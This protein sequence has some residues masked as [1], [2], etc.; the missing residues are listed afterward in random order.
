MRFLF[1]RLRLCTLL[2]DSYLKR[3]M[4]FG[5]SNRFTVFAKTLRSFRA[6]GGLVQIFDLNQCVPHFVRD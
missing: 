4:M 3:L 2:R 1:Q 6:K 5:L